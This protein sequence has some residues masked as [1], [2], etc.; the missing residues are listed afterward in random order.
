MYFD[1]GLPESQHNSSRCAG[2]FA[3]K[4]MG[5]NASKKERFGTLHHPR[6]LPYS[7]SDADVLAMHGES[8]EVIA[9]SLAATKA[10]T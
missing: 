7:M 3:F 5:N 1:Y 4:Y 10:C 9:A 6:L 8:A 2:T